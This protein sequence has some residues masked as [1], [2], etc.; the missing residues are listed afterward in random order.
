M[1][2]SLAIRHSFCEIHRLLTSETPPSWVFKHLKLEVFILNS[3]YIFICLKKTQK[4]CLDS[5]LVLQSLCNHNFSA[6]TTPNE[7]I[8]LLYQDVI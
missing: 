8:Y 6:F 4:H 1:V 5:V 3:D 2:A 7:D